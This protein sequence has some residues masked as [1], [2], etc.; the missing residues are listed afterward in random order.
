MIAFFRTII[1]V[2]L[3]NFLVLIYE[4]IS[5]DD[6]GVAIIILTIIIRIILYPIFF[7]SFKNQTILQRLQPEIQKIQHD[8][9]D[10]QEKK[11]RALMELYKKHRVNPFSNFGFLLIQMPI[12]IALY[13]LLRDLSLETILPDLY[14]FIPKPE[15]INYLFLGLIN[16]QNPNVI[17]VVLAAVGQYIQGKLALGRMPASKISDKDNPTAIMAKS[18]GKTMMFLGPLM[19]LLIFYRLPSALSLYWTITS[20]FSIIQQIIINKQLKGGVVDVGDP[21]TEI[22]Q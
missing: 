16:L 3:L 2:P 7:K 21:L 19:T 5:F 4:H 14:S 8:H 15:T 10:S 12:L 18:M 11:A 22:K 6:F 1:Y 20:V 9:K 13:W 17:L